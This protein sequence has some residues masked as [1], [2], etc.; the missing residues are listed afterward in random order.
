MQCTTVDTSTTCDLLAD[1]VDAT[2]YLNLPPDPQDRLTIYPIRH[3]DIWD[4]YKRALQSFWILEELDL[5]QD[6]ADWERMQPAE[7]NFILLILAWFGVGDSVVNANLCE[8]FMREINIAEV[9][10]FYC[11]QAAVEVI[12]QE[13]YSLLI[14]TFARSQTEREQL[15]L[16][17]LDIPAI[18]TKVTW[19]QKYIHSGSFLERLVAFATV[20]GLMF[21]S[22]FLAIFWLRKRGLMAGLSQANTLIARDEGQHQDFAALLYSYARQPLPQETVHDILTDAVHAEQEFVAAALATPLLGMNATQMNEYVEFVADR[23]C[24]Q[25]GC[26]PIY[27]AAN[28]YDW[29]ESV[30]LEGRNNMFEKRVTEYAR[31]GGGINAQD[32][33]FTMEADF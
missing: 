16:R 22:S 14:H 21:S 3:Q 13:V 28:P 4:S 5:S 7:Q 20:E 18:S 23:L 24:K 12:H 11:Q 10:A 27:H 15:L 2:M 17:A 8:R 26:E 32:R 31:T 19:A 33:V 9:K 1:S 25:L 29:M 30:S 6:L